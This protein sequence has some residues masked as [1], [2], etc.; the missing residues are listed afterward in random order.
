MN[1]KH[2]FPWFHRGTLIADANGLVVADTKSFAPADEQHNLAK[3][4]VE[5]VNLLAVVKQD[6]LIESQI[7]LILGFIES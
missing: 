1:L 7:K 3:F 2:P 5:A 6:P 4:I